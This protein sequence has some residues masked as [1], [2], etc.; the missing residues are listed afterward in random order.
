MTATEQEALRLLRRLT[1]DD[2]VEFRPGQLEAIRLL[3]EERRRVLLVQRT[4]WGKSAVYFIAT[5][6]LR[7]Q[8]AGPTL[9]VS[10][11]LALMRNQ[12]EAAEGMGVRAETIHS[13][14]R[15]EWDDVRTKIEA[16]AVDILLISP[17]RLANQRFRS[18]VLP[19]VGRRSGLLV[20]DEAHCISD[21]GHDFRPDYR[22]IVRVLNLL[23][24]GAP[25]LCCTATANDRVVEDV[26][27]Q[28]GSEL[29]LLR[30][31]LGRAGLRLHVLSMPSRAERMAW[32]AGIMPRLEGTGVIYVLTVR[33]TEHLAS[34]LR[35]R[36]IHAVAYSGRADG[37]SRLDIERSLLSNEMK[38]VVATSALGMGFDKPDLAFVIH[39]Q[40][41]GSPIAYYQQVGRAGRRL[42][43]SRG[44][45]LSGSEDRNIQDYFIT[46]AFSP[47]DLAAG[48]VSLLQDRAQPMSR[49][50]ILQEV[51]I[52]QS[53][54]NQL[55]KVLE[56]EGA[57]E[58]DGRG[59][60]RTL[61]PWSY[62]HDRVRAVTA[63]RRAEQAQM[64][65]YIRSE[66]CRMQLLRSYLDD[67]AAGPC[68]DCDNCLGDRM[69]V[70][71]RP[72]VRQQAE[73]YVSGAVHPI[74]PRKMIP[75]SGRISPERL[76]QPGRSLAAWGDEG[77][78]ELVR[79]GKY[80][81][82]RFDDRLVEASARLIRRVWHPEPSPAWLAFVPS[83][84]NPGLVSDFSARLADALGIACEDAVSKVRKTPQQSTRQ[85]NAQQYANVRGAFEV[86]RPVSSGPVLLVDDM[87]DSRWTMTAVGW[88]LLE[89][90]SGPVHP[91]ALADTSVG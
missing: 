35:S 42:D 45:L 47:V 63:Q 46:S 18:D 66:G 2:R 31:A 12:I 80:E 43:E 9:L 49:A 17:E 16:D 30:G 87:V 91:F 27:D 22:R 74:E 28:L 81:E 77:W 57:V 84:R 62:D 11:L 51:N 75:G 10:P 56:V 41:P 21:W 14:N 34:W 4:G 1:G 76:L 85:N 71:L 26:K 8:G 39:Y 24:S 29:V 38:A 52:R 23:P 15:G 83:L 72:T 64:L 73:E 59:W 25:L 40:S 13:G 3:A 61:R 5:R 69:S 7:D 79:R 19:M 54:F 90:G 44:I 6:M 65:E 58:R 60:L 37:D 78:S 88:L 32:L 86:C 33:D 67:Q 89:A 68:G 48:V 50:E 53:Q 20:I 82:G 55:M 70:D 36:G